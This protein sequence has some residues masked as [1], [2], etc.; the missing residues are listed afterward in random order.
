MDH[1]AESRVS[2]QT[3]VDEIDHI[4]TIDQLAEG[5]IIA[6]K[7]GRFLVCNRTARSLLSIGAEEAAELSWLQADGWYKSDGLTRYSF[8]ELPPTLAV[9][10]RTISETEVFIRNEQCPNGIWIALQAN[11]LLNKA[12]EIHGSVVAFR[13]IT[14]RRK[15]D[16][17]VRI[18]TG[19]VEQTADCIIITDNNAVIEYV[20]PAF[21]AITGFT[22]QE[23]LGHTPM[24]LKS[25]VHD[26]AFYA[27]L[28][29]T[30][31]AGKVFRDTIVN[32]KKNGEL[33]YAEQTITSMRD[34]TGAITHFV[35][36]IKDVTGLRQMQEQQFQMSLARAAQQQFYRMP[37]P[38]VPGFD[39]AG[40]SFPTDATGGDYFDFVTF[41]DN[42]IGIA[43]G[44]V[45]G[46]G[47]SAALLM[48]ELRAYLRAFAQTSSDI[49]EILTL[50]NGAL[51]S[52]L[53]Q[54]SYATLIFCRLHPGTRTIQYASA[55]HTPAFILDSRG[56]VK[57]TLESLDI[58]LGFLPG[59]KFKFS[60]RFIL[61]PGEILALLT[62]GITDAE[63]PDGEQFGV[64]RALAFIQ[65][66]RKESAKEIAA[67][68]FHAV[69]EFEDGMPQVDDITVVICKAAGSQ[70]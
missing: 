67:N 25:G 36:V 34:S 50:M 10:G 14:P 38:S 24:I 11:P 9:T 6:D 35:T 43:T 23:A 58:P 1:K 53:E 62:D 13:D 59:Y 15:V 19:A 16:A 60:E 61:E 48:A 45:S 17:Q 29:R 3:L 12:G 66:H 8:E 2:A 69:R 31:L 32:R 27:N 42:C 55:G 37:P 30:I 57:K 54:G 40:A 56:A 65:Q 47:V 7:A 28:W 33:F 52:D 4:S 20:N 49:G 26:D 44:D 39:L 22:S 70:H 51:I 21:E 68:L 46:H 18:L 5:L 63:R 64:E 41:P